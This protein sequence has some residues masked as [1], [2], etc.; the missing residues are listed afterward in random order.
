M[1]IGRPCKR[2]SPHRA[3]INRREIRIADVRLRKTRQQPR[4][5]DGDRGA[6]QDVADAMMRTGAERKDALWLPVDVE[7]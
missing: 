2:S 5:R 1:R 3:A 7:A 6:P 4:D